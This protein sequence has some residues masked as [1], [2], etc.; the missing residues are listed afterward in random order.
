MIF[1]I[2]NDVYNV[3]GI[4]DRLFEYYHGL[5]MIDDE[6]VECQLEAYSIHGKAMLV[7]QIIFSCAFKFNT[8]SHKH[9]RA[10]ANFTNATLICN[11]DKY[12]CITHATIEKQFSQQQNKTHQKKKKK[13]ARRT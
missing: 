10:R 9:P 2:K 3:P 6:D 13:N 12:V 8:H 5:D 11:E 1:V 7:A 4:S